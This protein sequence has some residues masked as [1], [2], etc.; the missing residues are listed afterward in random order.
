[1]CVCHVRTLDQPVK[2]SSYSGGIE[3]NGGEMRQYMHGLQK[4]RYLKLYDMG[5]ASF[6]GGRHSSLNRILPP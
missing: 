4:L 1:M 5:R 3:G 2:I 6:G